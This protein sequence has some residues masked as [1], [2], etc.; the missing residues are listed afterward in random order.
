[1]DVPVVPAKRGRGKP[2]GYPKT[3]GK[4][5]GYKFPATLA[6]E[7]AREAARKRITDRLIPLVDAQIDN[8]IGIKHFMLR[9]AATGQWVRLTDPDQIV[10]AMNHPRAK[11]GSTYLIYTKDPNPNSAR[12]M[13]AYAIDRPKEQ[14]Q[15]I[16]VK[17]S[18][19][20]VKKLMEGRARAAKA[21]RET[22]GE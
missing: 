19:E 16:D 21:Q 11:H 1:M 17:S 12:D 4:Q 15:E 6:K 14:V 8:A 20:L 7:A 22:G 3:G 18:D 9:D 5:K 13:L 10:A 2:K